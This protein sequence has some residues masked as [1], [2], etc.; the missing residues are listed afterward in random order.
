MTVMRRGSGNDADGVVGGV[1]GG[2]C[3]RVGVL[4]SDAIMDFRGKFSCR[5]MRGRREGDGAW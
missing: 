2:M 5:Y 1:G 3:G 4:V